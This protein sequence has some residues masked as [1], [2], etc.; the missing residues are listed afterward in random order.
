MEATQALGRRLDSLESPSERELVGNALIVAQSFLDE[1]G[2]TVAEVCSVINH[3]SHNVPA[4]VAARLHDLRQAG[5]ATQRKNGGEAKWLLTPRGRAKYAA[6]GTMPDRQYFLEK[7]AMPSSKGKVHDVSTNQPYHYSVKLAYKGPQGRTIYE[8]K[9]DMTEQQFRDQFLVPY[10]TGR[11]IVVNGKAIAMANLESL[12]VGITLQTFDQIVEQVRKDD[13]ESSVVNLSPPPMAVRAFAYT[14]DVTDVWITQPPG[15]PGN[16]EPRTSGRNVTSNRVFV[17]HGHDKVLLRDVEAFLRRH[18]VDPIIIN[19]ELDRGQ[20]IIEKIERG[21][22]QARYGIVLLTPD[23]VGASKSVVT[24]TSVP[25]S[26]LEPRAR[27]NAILEWGYLAGKL[28]REHVCCI[29]KKPTQLPSDLHGLV[30]KQVQDS[31]D[32]V[33]LALLREMKQSGLEIEIS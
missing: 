30:Y 20:T 5:W 27:Q 19:A 1:T 2:V 22:A 11:A 32:E 33:A 6:L 17:V 14:Q 25:V 7:A 28:G 8:A 31:I 16:A 29:V 3:S 21:G 26:S 23:D 9:H 15:R 24:G 18:G 10:E 13:D 4:N 12:Q